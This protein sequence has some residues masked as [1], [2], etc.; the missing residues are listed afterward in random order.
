MQKLIQFVNLLG[1]DVYRILALRFI[2]RLVNNG[3]QYNKLQ[4]EQ[5]GMPLLLQNIYPVLHDFSDSAGSINTHYFHMDLW[6]ARKIYAANPA[7]H[8]DIGS[9]VDGFI[10]HLLTFRTVTMID[11]R[12]LC[13]SV[14]GLHFQQDDATTLSSVADN[15]LESVSTLH[16]AEHFGLGR[17]NDPI[18]PLAHE[19][20][21]KSLTRVL[22]P[23]GRLYFAV[24]IG[25]ERLEFNA[26]RVFS[27]TS[28]LALFSGL[29]PISF[30]A[31]ND[32]G[33]FVEN[34]N[35]NAYENAHF[36]CGLFEFSK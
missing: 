17:Y 27:P 4:T 3:R 5:G 18:D 26:Q 33:E 2:V 23:G 10:A 8:Y 16:A 20:F 36:S 29:K 1:I 32:K 35:I 34:A 31:V 21:I 9:R 19:K 14:S 22:K 7:A 25:W 13:G 24:P 30:S 12:P 6:A 15:S 11:V 28:V